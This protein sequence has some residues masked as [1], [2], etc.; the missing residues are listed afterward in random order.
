MNS[1]PISPAALRLMYPFLTVPHYGIHYLFAIP[2]W[3]PSEI[4][5]FQGFAPGLVDIQDLF[6][7]LPHLPADI[8]E[9]TYSAEDRFA[10]RRAGIGS[11]YWAIANILSFDETN[12]PSPLA[13]FMVV[14]TTDKE[15]A[16][17]VSSWMSVLPIKPLHVSRFPGKH[18]ISPRKL[19]WRYLQKHCKDILVQAKKVEDNLNIDPLIALIN[20]WRP[21]ETHT[22][23]L[24]NH[25]HGV[26]MVNEMVL[27]S[28][29]YASPT[30]EAGRL[31]NSKHQQYIDG[32]TQ[33]IEPILKLQGVTEGQG[34]FLIHPPRPDIILVAP[35]TFRGIWK[36]LSKPKLPRP[37]VRAAKALNRQTGYR[38]DL[39]AEILGGLN[40]TELAEF[41][42][43]QGL[44][45]SELSLQT[46]AFGFRAMSTLAA[47]IRLPGA[48]NGVAVEVKKFSDHIRSRDGGSV[49]IKTARVFKGVQDAL[50]NAVPQEH[51][52]LI[53][54][55]QSGIKIIGNAPLEWLPINGLPLGI[56]T[57]VSRINATP[58]NLMFQHLQETMPI[59]LSPETFKEYVV[60]SMF[61]EGDSL[62]H[63]IENAL[64]SLSTQ[65]NL[66]GRIERPTSVEEFAHA[67]DTYQGSILII[68]SHGDHPATP[69]VGGLI[70]GGKPFEVVDLSGKIRVPPIVILSAC[71]THPYDRSHATVANGFLHCGAIAVLS[72]VLS[73][74]GD[75]AALFLARLLLRAVQYAG[76]VTNSGQT[77]AWTNIVGG[78]LRM[79]LA[80][81]IVTRLAKRKLITEEERNQ[82]QFETNLD[83]NRPRRDWLDRLAER[84]KAIGGIDET[85]WQSLFADILAGSDVIRYL[86][87]GNPES[88]L[89]TD[90]KAIQRIH[91][92][93]LH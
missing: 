21:L 4:T 88:I 14:F 71:D 34:V 7:F 87:I 84:C 15:V 78:A 35:S 74:R 57:D 58:G 38:L 69:D 79:H 30:N 16:K 66:Q 55:S 75:Q 62:A 90:P 76:Y 28:C 80:F 54:K 23:I 19:T 63:Y 41:L 26:T 86:H 25:S 36:T 52:E 1:K 47:A 45:A 68:D 46:R 72:T 22:S 43:L 24:K 49:P 61:Q 8:E 12:T 64:T 59:H 81:D 13:P 65:K 18:G 48:I 60:L 20:E 83:I 33:S 56:W 92:N 42:W 53:S 2:D 3:K 11:W 93:N 73:I 17:Q 29:G 91:R 51:V 39:G 6:S 37:L 44:R 67:V 77:V 5:A 82:I 50:L 40:E 27:Q 31:G 89:I 10:R 85:T 70:I 9:W 32:I